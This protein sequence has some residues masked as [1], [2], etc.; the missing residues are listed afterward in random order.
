VLQ[1]PHLEKAAKVTISEVL[2]NNISVR[3][4]EEQLTGLPDY[5][6]VEKGVNINGN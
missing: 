4:F 3:V 1:S 5:L 2:D 6:R